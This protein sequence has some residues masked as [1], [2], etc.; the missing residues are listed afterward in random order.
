M[1]DTTISNKNNLVYL[2]NGPQH[3][4]VWFHFI[5]LDR[6]YGVYTPRLGGWPT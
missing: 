3:I 6:I 1:P 2:S 5:Y 4:A